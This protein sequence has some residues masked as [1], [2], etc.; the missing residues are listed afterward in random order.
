MMELSS[1]GEDPRLH[2]SY[3]KGKNKNSNIQLT[4]HE[5]SNLIFNETDLK[6]KV[7]EERLVKLNTTVGTGRSE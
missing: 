4:S 7:I 5:S 1:S 2:S 3:I 6:D